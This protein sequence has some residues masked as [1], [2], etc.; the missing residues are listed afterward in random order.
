MLLLYAAQSGCP[1]TCFDW[2][3]P[4]LKIFLCKFSSTLRYELPPFPSIS[5]L[6]WMTVGWTDACMHLLC[7][8]RGTL[9]LPPEF[10]KAYSECSAIH[11][12]CQI[13]CCMQVWR[14]DWH[15]GSGEIT[16]LPNALNPQNITSLIHG[17]K[18]WR[19]QDTVSCLVLGPFKYD[20]ILS[21]ISMTKL[22]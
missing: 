13:R 8:H 3:L 22:N 5:S 7:L 1:T 17:T 6:T 18:V 11:E 20:C 19:W 10:S 9:F 14:I 2:R 16:A 4:H 12:M 21:K 15:A